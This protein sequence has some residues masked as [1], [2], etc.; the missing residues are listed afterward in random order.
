M[1]TLLI[2]TQILYL[3]CLVPWYLIWG[4]SFMTFDNGYSIYNVT[5]VLLIS[6]YPIAVLTCSII[7]WI[8]RKRRRRISAAVN[9]IPMLWVISL[10][11]S[12]VINI[13]IY[14]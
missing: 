2:T 14:K 1:K 9:F 8:L 10:V 4:L 7:A 13:L 12:I 3:L 6:L 5:F 11:L